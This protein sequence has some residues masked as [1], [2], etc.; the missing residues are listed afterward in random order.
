MA[1]PSL[2]SDLSYSKS[3]AKPSRWQPGGSAATM[4]VADEIKM[5]EISVPSELRSVLLNINPVVSASVE[6]TE[7]LFERLKKEFEARLEE[8]LKKHMSKMY[9]Q[10]QESIFNNHTCVVCKKKTLD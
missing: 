7:E 3:G 5:P 1:L 9:K 4:N 10:F 6:D 8:N 2:L